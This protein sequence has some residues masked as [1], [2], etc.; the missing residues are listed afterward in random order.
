MSNRFNSAF[1]LTSVCFAL[2]LA[3]GY[4]STSLAESAST[5]SQSLHHFDLPADAL[6]A[7]L[8]RIARQS[9]SEIVY[10]PNLAAGLRAPAIK[11]TMNAEQAAQMAIEGS[12]LSVR[13]TSGGTLTLDAF[14]SMTLPKPRPSPWARKSRCVCARCRRRST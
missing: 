11:G 9:D 13:T 1:R 4:A 12:G 14:G 6:A 2:L 7:T 10:V 8:D 3:Q 5:G